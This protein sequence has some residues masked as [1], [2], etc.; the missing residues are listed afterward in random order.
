VST[1]TEKVIIL[2]PARV[3]QTTVGRKPKVVGEE[4][5]GVVSPTYCPQGRRWR[6]RR[7]CYRRSEK[8]HSKKG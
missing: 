4:A 1:V 6:K 3:I 5:V 8:L 2:E 7:I